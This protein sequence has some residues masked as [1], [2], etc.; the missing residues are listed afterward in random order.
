M[1]NDFGDPVSLL[2]PNLTAVE[3]VQAHHF[4]P[5]REEVTH[6]PLLGIRAPFPE[7]SLVLP[8]NFHSLT[9]FGVGGLPTPTR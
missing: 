2:K 6:E 7:V 4:V 9:S 1:L 8:S 5:G 3:T